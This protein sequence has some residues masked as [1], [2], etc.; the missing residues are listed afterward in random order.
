[1]PFVKSLKKNKREDV[2]NK[3]LIAAPCK[4]ISKLVEEHVCHQKMHT[5]ILR[6]VN[7]H[8]ESSYVPTINKQTSLNKPSS[9]LKLLKNY[10]HQEYPG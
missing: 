6:L 3:K 8:D 4:A 2:K 7:D 5:C 9:K 1:M 10:F